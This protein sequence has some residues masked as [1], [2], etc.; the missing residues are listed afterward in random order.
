MKEKK[1]TQNRK[2]GELNYKIKQ[3]GQ[4]Q[5]SSHLIIVNLVSVALLSDL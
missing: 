1:T 5:Q 4:I 2:A 3:Q